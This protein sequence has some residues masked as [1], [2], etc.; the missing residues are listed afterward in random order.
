MIFTSKNNNVDFC[1]CFAEMEQAVLDDIINR[2]LEVRSR[3]GKQ[4]Q[5]SETEIRQLCSTAREIFLQ[6]PNLLELEAPIKICGNF[7]N[8]VFLFYY[9]FMISCFSM[10][11]HDLF[12]NMTFCLVFFLLSGVH[13]SLAVYE[14]LR[15]VCWRWIW[16]EFVCCLSFSL[17]QENNSC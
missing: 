3:P 9:C 16:I 11:F 17:Y 6:Q 8:S 7:F 12:F 4:V 15:E 5:L 2:L 1:L 10:G 13:D 14:C